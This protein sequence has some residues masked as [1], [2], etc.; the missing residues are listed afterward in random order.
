[1]IVAMTGCDVQGPKLIFR[2]RVFDLSVRL[3]QRP[4]S[5]QCQPPS[6]SMSQ[7][8]ATSP[9]SASQSSAFSLSSLT[10]LPSVLVHLVMQQ[11]QF[12]ELARLASTCKL[13]RT[14]ALHPSVGRF[15]LS[16]ED[17]VVSLEPPHS[18][19]EI[20]AAED[21]MLD[22]I[23]VLQRIHSPLGRAHLPAMILANVELE[24]PDSAPDLAALSHSQRV[25]AL[26]EKIAG[27]AHAETLVLDGAASWPEEDALAL[28]QSPPIQRINHVQC[29]AGV[30]LTEP[31]LTALCRLPLLESLDA[32]LFDRARR[33]QC[34][35][36]SALVHAHS[37]RSLSV[38]GAQVPT[39]R[40]AGLA[41]LSLRLTRLEL[42]IDEFSDE[43][44]DAEE[45]LMSWLVEHCRPM[46]SRLRVLQLSNFNLAALSY[47]DMRDLFCAMSALRYLQTDS[48]HPDRI[49]RG[50]STQALL[51]RCLICASYASGKIDR[52]V[53]PEKA[54][55]PR[56]C[57]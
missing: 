30:W 46:L 23:R 41:S 13:M 14:D 33:T 34:L 36:S 53:R 2:L 26:A 15:L 56:L 44:E 25:T 4:S 52:A 55:S 29:A 49:L 19:S 32:S 47:D 6:H 42:R 7:L 17:D 43:R 18:A 45:K 24:R 5:L 20:D 37:L 10:H 11:V 3:D 28:L 12:E 40:L 1:M 31:V 48:W 38:R 22:R 9:A 50:L 35:H 39:S 8:L 16:N 57:C 21:W 54:I 27:W 51:R